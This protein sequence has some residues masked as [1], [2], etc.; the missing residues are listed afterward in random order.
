MGETKTKL[1]QVESIVST[2]DKELVDLKETMKRCEQ[3]F[4]NMGFIDA[5]NSCDKVI[6]EARR[7][8]FSEGCMAIVNA[9]NLLDSSPFSNPSQ[10]PQPNVPFVTVPTEEQPNE[11]DEEEGKRA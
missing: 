1:A 4:Y 5:E 10:I 7:H 11:E 8:G 3:A 2:R 9:I 6:F